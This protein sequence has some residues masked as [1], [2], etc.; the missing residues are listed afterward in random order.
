[1][2]ALVF[3]CAS[4]SDPREPAAAGGTPGA[5]G[6]PLA[7]SASG[8]T[9]GG[10]NGASSSD[11]AGIAGNGGTAPAGNA[12]GQNGGGSAGTRGGSAGNGGGG[13]GPGGS[14]PSAGCVEG[15]ELSE[16]EH[17]LQVAG[18]T[19]KYVLRL[20]ED[21]A[22]GKPWPL[23]LAL[24]PNDNNTDYW[25]DTTGD[26]ALRPLLAKEAVLVLPQAR[27]TAQPGLGDWR[28]DLPAD[29]AYF[30]A[31]LSQIKTNSCIDEARIFAMGF[32]GGGSFSGVLGCER[33]DIRAIAAG[34]AVIYFDESACVGTPAA[35][36]TIG[37]D[38]DEPARLDYRDFFRGD[39]DCGET[40]TPV[41]PAPCVAYT[42]PSPE[43]PVHFCAHPG[44][45]VWPSFGTEA[46]WSFFAQF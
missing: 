43:R 18:M 38:E 6:A 44:G 35:W 33:T 40:S 28:G 16:G 8:A 37:D 21:H 23:V 32:S 27:P 42:C 1:M 36:I 12:S 22:G 46:A 3:G 11:H 15:P 20:P 30:E 25:D 19:R 2:S 39:A 26:R 14:K 10:T 13:S 24:H 29:L 4:T 41:P 45:H 5:G 9:A 31:L 7:G 17:E 34:G